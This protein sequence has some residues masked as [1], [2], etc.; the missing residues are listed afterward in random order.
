V[1]VQLKVTPSI[2]QDGYVTMK[3]K[4][5]VSSVSST[6]TTALGN[7]IPIV[8]TST[9]ET[10]VMVKDGT[11]IVIAGLMSEKSTEK[12]E[13]IPL[14]G[15]LP[16]IGAAFKGWHETVEKTELVFFLTPTIISGRESVTGVASLFEKKKDEEK[17]RN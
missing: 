2:N 9:A 4:P 5:E 1:G 10:T 12:T 7:Q 17:S 8:A 11:T 6:L 16:F 3:I 13:K 14:L 15:D